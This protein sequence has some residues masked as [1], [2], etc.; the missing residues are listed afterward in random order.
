MKVNI[1]ADLERLPTEQLDGILQAEIGKK[2]PN[3][4]VVLSVLKILKEREGSAPVV[5]DENVRESWAHYRES[6]AADRK[7]A[8]RKR[9]WLAV[10]IATA[11]AAV[12]ILVMAI[13]VGARS[14][15]EI[16]VSWTESIFYYGEM[17]EQ[18]YVF[19][20]NHPGLQQIYDAVVAAGVDQPVVPRWLPEGSELELFEV[21]NAAGMTKIFAQFCS[22]DGEIEIS[23][24][25]NPNSQY[26]E[27]AKGR[28]D[29]KMVDLAGMQHYIISNDGTWTAMW[30]Q[31]RVEC[32]I[33]VVGR[34]KTL[35]KILDSIYTME[36][37]NQ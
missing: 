17:D 1:K 7:E 35:Y 28:A 9:N 37:H 34:E 6:C 30:V 10:K 18:P 16:V 8:A 2:Q 24:I 15:F 33:S 3:E 29:V 22:P 36:V 31:D 25:L 5:I 26:G 27:Y 11:A 23:L 32:S 12:L 14:V 4:D 20:A 13:P 19:E 21:N